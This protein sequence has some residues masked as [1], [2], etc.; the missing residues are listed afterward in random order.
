M[1]GEGGVVD[2]WSTIGTLSTLVLVVD[3]L[4]L[5]TIEE[6]GVKVASGGNN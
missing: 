3:P 6:D 4:S 2:C 5:P 1:A